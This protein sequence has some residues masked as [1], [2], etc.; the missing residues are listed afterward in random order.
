MPATKKEIVQEL[1][2]LVAN[3]EKVVNG[4]A[5]K[6][7]TYQCPKPTCLSKKIS[8][9]L[10]SGYQNPY[11][12]LRSCYGR[13]LNTAEQ[14]KLIH[15]MYEE[16][17]AAFRSTGGSIS[18]HFKSDTLSELEKSI[19]SWVRLIIIESCPFSIVTSKEF[20]RFNRY[21]AD[22]GIETVQQ[23]IIKMVELVELRI[24]KEMEKTK[25]AIMFDG[26]SKRGV[27]YVA[28]VASYVQEVPVKKRDVVC[29]EH[30]QRLTLIALSPMARHTD[31]AEIAAVR[32]ELEDDV[33]PAEDASDGEEAEAVTFNAA[34]TFSSCATT[35]STS[36]VTSIAGWCV[37]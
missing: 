14:D 26:W 29:T 2:S 4:K 12:H 33:S 25:G 30:V 1:M 6:Y 27:H 17:R 28:M 10:G 31:S 3:E 8:F 34:T 11:A 16:A 15:G 20:R 24:Q 35:S 19:N 22:V 36:A 5:V 32:P 23:T 37:S 9:Q 18:S 13:G 7:V 21:T